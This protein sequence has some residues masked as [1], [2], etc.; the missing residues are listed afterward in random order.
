MRYNVFW[1]WLSLW[2]VRV[3]RPNDPSSATRPRDAMIA[4]A[5]PRRV[6]CQRM[7]SRQ[8]FHLSLIAFSGPPS[9][10]SCLG[11]DA[12]KNL[13]VPPRT[14]DH[15]TWRIRV[16]LVLETQMAKPVHPLSNTSYSLE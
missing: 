15:Y 14:M 5:T 13:N 2:H 16:A 8:S 12:A 3:V 9:V 7:V 10:M 1:F 11:Q 6:R 4:T